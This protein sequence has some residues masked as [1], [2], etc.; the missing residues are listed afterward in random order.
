MA[1]KW[2]LDPAHSEVNFKAKHLVISTVSGKFKKFDGIAET[3][4]PDNFNNAKVEFTIDVASIDTNQA[5]RDEHL[6]SA[7]FFDAANHPQIVFKS[8][9]FQ[10][11]DDEDDVFELKGDL[12]IRGI[13]K[14]IVLDVEFGGTATDAYGNFKAGFEVSGKVSRKEFGLSW[15]A[16]TEA[17]AIV[18]GDT[19]KFQISVQF[20]RQ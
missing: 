19:I 13:T 15:N 20:I 7:D 16:V 8:S 17:G 9:G 4:S 1:T 18:V 14:P 5:P 12:T 6:R 11:E 3:E 2:V 10:L